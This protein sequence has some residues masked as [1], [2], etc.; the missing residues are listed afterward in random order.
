[1]LYSVV[2]CTAYIIGI[3]W[4]LYLGFNLSIVSFLLLFCLYFILEPVFT[5]N[6]TINKYRFINYTKFIFYNKS[7]Y[8]KVI[9]VIFASFLIGLLNASFR[10]YDFE[11]KY[12]SRYFFWAR[13]NY[14][15]GK[16]RYIL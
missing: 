12:N 3:I 4:G 14:Q 6:F 5:K 16:K 13:P 15:N 7:V 11:T 8:K 9:I 1:M 2:I 10:I